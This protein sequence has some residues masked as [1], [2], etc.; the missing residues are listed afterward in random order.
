MIKPHPRSS[1]GKLRNFMS[2]VFI[3]FL[4]S[5]LIFSGLLSTTFLGVS[6]QSD[7]NSRQNNADD[8]V[9]QTG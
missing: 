3:L 1:P 6:A 2:G 5:S 4:I 7:N 9:A 8:R